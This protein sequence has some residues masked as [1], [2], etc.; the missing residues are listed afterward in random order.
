MNDKIPANPIKA[1]DAPRFVDELWRGIMRSGFGAWSKNDIYD[2]LLY[3][4]NKYDE[5][6]FFD[7]NSNEKNERLL[8][9]TATKIRASRTNISV[10]FLDDDEYGGVFEEFL[11]AFASGRIA[12]KDGTQ[13]KIKL[14]IENPVFRKALENRLKE[15]VQESF[16]YNLNSEKVEISCEAF[17]TMLQGEAD[18]LKN[19]DKLV[20]ILQE[21][22][23]I[24]VQQT[25]Q[26]FIDKVAQ[27]PKDF[28]ASFFKG[29]IPQMCKAFYTKNLK[30]KQ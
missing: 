26:D 5:R 24:N 6:R 28:G 27:A 3:L 20:K 8:K 23:A 29:F 15:R 18:R 11:Q 19:S 2:Y 9:T 12:I 16:D 14:T 1:Q 22:K 10:K 7:S 25:A 4:F 21:S 17:I 13:G 30:E